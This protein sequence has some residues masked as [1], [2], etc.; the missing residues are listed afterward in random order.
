LQKFNNLYNIKK[1]KTYLMGSGNCKKK[2]EKDDKKE[3]KYTHN[4]SRD[5][6]SDS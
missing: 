3:I 1:K 4:L 6:N 2:I 5:G